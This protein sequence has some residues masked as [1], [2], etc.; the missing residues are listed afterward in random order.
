MAS[1]PHLPNQPWC[2]HSPQLDD[3]LDRTPVTVTLD[4]PVV[5]VLARMSQ[6]QGCSCSQEGEKTPESPQNPLLSPST[7]CVLVTQGTQLVGIFTERDVVRLTAQGRNLAGVSIRQVMSP[8]DYRLKSSEF[9]DVFSVLGILKQY[10]IRHLPVVDDQE[11]LLGLI[12]LYTLRSVIEPSHLLKLRT[13]DEVMNRTVIQAT[14]DTSV[15]KLAQLMARHRVS[16]VVIC[17]ADCSRHLE[18]STLDLTPQPPSF[19]PARGENSQHLSLQERGLE[20]GFLDPVKSNI[21]QEFPAGNQ[22]K[23]VGIITE[24]DIVQFQVLGVNLS[25]LQAKDVMSQ[26]LFYLRT[27]D[28]L[29]HAH[30]EMQRRYVR[31]L[32]VT[33]DTGEL[34]GIVTQT[35]LLQVLDPMEMY[36]VI[37]QLQQ[38][39]GQLEAEKIDLLESRNTQLEELVQSRTHQL[40]KQAER[41]HILRSI[42]QRIRCF[43]KLPDIFQ[44]TVKEVRQLLHCDRVLVYQFAED[45]SGEIVAESVGDF[46]SVLGSQV[47]DAYFQ[48]T[49]GADYLNGR[50]QVA[51]NIYHQGLTPCHL[52][53]LEQFQVKA[54]LTVPIIINEQL[55]GLLVAH[56]CAA[57]RPWEPQELDLLEQLSVQIAIA[58]QQANAFSQLQTELA[59]RQKA[60]QLAKATQERLHYLLSASPTAI[61]SRQFIPPYQTTFISDNITALIGYTPGEILEQPDFWLN[62]IH[63]QDLPTV[64]TGFAQ[65]FQQGYSIQEYRFKQKNGEYLWLQDDWKLIRN[66]QGIPQEIIG[67]W[68]DI[69]HRVQAQEHAQ[70]SEKLLEL[71]YESAPVGL[72]ITDEQWRLVRVNPAF[73]QLFAYPRDYLLGRSLTE[74]LDPHHSGEWQVRRHDGKF[75]DIQVTTGPIMQQ[76]ERCLRVT[77][78]TDITERKKA[79][80]AIQSMAGQLSTVI[81]TVGEGI[82]LS[83]SQGKF[84]IF[85]HQ[86]QQIT[87]Y[88]RQEANR[89]E[90]FMAKLYPDPLLYQQVKQWQ[91]SPSKKRKLRT[92]ETTFC[93]KNGVQKTLLVSHSIIHQDNQLLFLSA[94]RDISDRKQAEESLKHLNEALEKRVQERTTALE[95]TVE[96][97]H[98]EIKE[99]QQT[100]LALQDSHRKINNIL[101]SITEGFFA[102]DQDWRFTHF[103]SLLA[104]LINRPV[105]DMIGR[106][107]WDEFPDAIGTQFETIYRQAAREQKPMAFE[108]LY[109]S[110]NTWYEVR[111]YP[112]EDGLSVYFRDISDRKKA[113]LALQESQR[114]I[115]R[116][117]DTN[118]NVLY[119]YDIAEQRNI[120]INRSVAQVLGYSPEQ[121]QQMESKLFE[122]L[123]H[124]DDLAQVLRQHQRFDTAKDGDII[125]CEYRMRHAD[126]QWRWLYSW[127]TIFTRTSEGKPKQL[128]GTASDITSRKQVEE[129]L[130]Q[131]V[132]RERLISAMSRRIRQ[133]LDL[134]TILTTTVEEIQQLLMADRVL[135]YQL[136]EDN[137]GRVIAEGVASGFPQLLNSIFPAE[138]FPPTCYQ[139]YV[140]GKVYTLAD[141]DREDVLP[142]MVDFMREYAIRAKLV[143]PIVQQDIL[144]GLLIVHQCSHP[145]EWQTW[146]IELLVSLATQLAIAIKQS[147]LYEQLRHNNDILATTNAEL[148]HATRLKDEFLANMSHELR[149]P[150][151]AILG[152]SESL[153][154]EVYG[155]I[156]EKQRKSLATIEKSGRHLL[157]LIN[158]I[159]DLAKIESGKLE[160]NLTAVRISQLCDASLSLIKPLALDKNITL[161]GNIAAGL[162]TILGDERRLQ[163]V[164]INLL[165]NAVKF[166][167][168]GGQVTVE[169]RKQDGGDEEDKE[170]NATFSQGGFCS[171]VTISSQKKIPKP[172]PTNHTLEGEEG[173]T[174]NTSPNEMLYISVSDTGIGIAKEHREKLFQSFVQIDSSLSRRHQGTGLG[175]ALVRRIVELHGG[176][177]TVESEIGKGSCF[178]VRLPWRSHPVNHSISYP[179]EKAT[180]GCSVSDIEDTT[181][182]RTTPLILL[183]EDNEANTQTL[184]D[185]LQ[186]IGY[187]MIMAKDGKEAVQLSQRRKPDLILMDIQMPELDGLS[188]TQQIR[189][190]PRTATIPIIAITALA[191]SGD[192]EKCLAAGVS[193]YMTK[194]VNLKKLATII[195]ALLTG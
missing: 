35:R 34:L 28:N 108:E 129:T 184:S 57:P 95:Q 190:N 85:N 145:R 23:P 180:L 92:F 89:C 67:A 36:G 168:E 159:L 59:E 182:L 132:E 6:V 83:N 87:G 54:I 55:W 18:K 155:E 133:S 173:L 65:L 78:V 149:T 119:I 162:G 71:F 138:T 82:T 181:L 156:T 7:S 56:H 146:E 143:V 4:T 105:S 167:P 77:T 117:A 125:E 183:A 17:Q 154:E 176:W 137:R 61:Y 170:V 142:C 126:G 164:L 147:Q 69:S 118:P 172:A 46:P 114:F 32:V 76:G 175:L 84:R 62:H 22:Q 165:S 93:D 1:S 174:F 187:E 75:I 10:Q 60:E 79:E 19:P 47:R 97:L 152:L 3:I 148:A 151:N 186:G 9:R 111:V 38:V 81:D 88:T 112:S 50:R 110:N 53:L 150:L 113:E 107:I 127:D 120:Y 103:N 189:A 139:N 130:R 14:V 106:C 24:R 25:G 102:L 109:A 128:L 11:Q 121:I 27:Q 58:I 43:L 90:N 51:H 191:M 188:A 123:M 21:C 42:A 63:P 163:Q 179:A 48:E 91:K 134:E 171:N 98:R 29:W 44:A 15:L 135:V 20:R 72:C 153:Q 94:Y 31:R 193:Y 5:E 68:L 161:S 124:P 195:N 160:L 16:C 41:E 96:H 185:Y 12:T 30:Q 166:T 49:K 194:P 73:C 64:L 122:S 66:D 104:P 74:F 178:T 26:P 144:W 136:F 101:E 169:I 99:R 70:T 141:R 2:F 140:Q 192:R 52:E 40:Q 157:E 158:D 86:M 33:G 116:I 131:Q 13:V 80:Q 8:P 37:D 39:I 115:Q 45:W 177:V 100:E